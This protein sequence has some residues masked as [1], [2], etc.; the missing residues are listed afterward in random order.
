[1]EYD[2]AYYGHS[3]RIVTTQDASGSWS[4]SADLPEHPEL[5]LESRSA[6]SEAEARGAALSAAYGAL[7][8]LRERVGK[9]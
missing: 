4:A 8:K 5:R 3:I 9:P 6:A 7:D 1:M 2:E